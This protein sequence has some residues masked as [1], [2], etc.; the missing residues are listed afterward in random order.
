MDL[1]EVRHKLTAGYERI[2]RMKNSITK[3]E[4]CRAKLK[5]KQERILEEVKATM[6]QTAIQLYELQQFIEVT[7][8]ATVMEREKQL[9]AKKKEIHDGYAKLV[10]VCVEADK[11]LRGRNDDLLGRSCQR[12]FNSFDA[13]RFK[14]DAAEKVDVEGIIAFEFQN[15][16]KQF[17]SSTFVAK[18]Q[19]LN[20]SQKIIEV[21]EFWVGS[22][23]H[24]TSHAELP[25]G[26]EESDSL[27]SVSNHEDSFNNNRP[28]PP[29]RPPERNSSEMPKPP[30]ATIQEVPEEPMRKQKVGMTRH[31]PASAVELI[32]IREVDLCHGGE[33][34]N[35]KAIR[36]RIPNSQ[37]TVIRPPPGFSPL[38]T[39]GLLSRDA[40]ADVYVPPTLG[41]SINPLSTPDV[42]S[43][44]SPD[45]WHAG[46]H[47][48]GLNPDTSSSSS[49]PNAAFSCV[50]SKST[51]SHYSPVQRSRTIPMVTKSAERSR[52]EDDFIWDSDDSTDVSNSE[53]GS[54]K[55]TLTGRIGTSEHGAESKLSSVPQQT[56]QVVKTS[57]SS[58]PAD[59]PCAKAENSKPMFGSAKLAPEPHN[60]QGLSTGDTG[61]AVSG[62]TSAKG[63]SHFSQLP[64][65]TK[66]PTS[67][68]T[69]GFPKNIALKTFEQQSTFSCSTS[70]GGNRR[71]NTASSAAQDINIV[72]GQPSDKHQYASKET[73]GLT[74]MEQHPN[75]APKEETKRETLSIKREDSKPN[76]KKEDSK[77]QVKEEFSF[78][79]V[80]NVKKDADEAAGSNFTDAKNVGK[81]PDEAA[82]CK[83][84]EV[85][86]LVKTR[87]KRLDLSHMLEHVGGG[88][89]GEFILIKSN[90]RISF[91]APLKH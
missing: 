88:V 72:L 74:V 42:S 91:L 52:D 51:R 85:P 70:D 3:V 64:N 1:D 27:L 63:V 53:M 31:R 44:S 77:P 4:T 30:L 18:L 58:R 25:V 55:S 15:N 46:R 23:G 13:A 22:S 49:E 89:F 7:V 38:Q 14:L 81:D 28:I 40:H 5:V 21:D 87:S 45:C 73:R 66:N 17:L 78:V 59:L 36:M 84:V 11:V 54:R 47:G 56:E 29:R 50:S 71:P 39:S 41:R 6:N 2:N 37:S 68:A 32:Q 79:D 82:G 24:R 20:R 80:E 67:G 48:D 16:M 60:S 26:R 57:H 8:R 43:D 62:S 12:L 19:H 9:D 90:G 65:S 83:V 75:T 35:D 33:L 34:E 76:V 86:R 69:K 10:Q 61:K